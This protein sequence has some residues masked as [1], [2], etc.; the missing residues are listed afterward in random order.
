MI[1]KEALLVARTTMSHPMGHLQFHRERADLA[2]QGSDLELHVRAGFLAG[3]IHRQ[4]T[5]VIPLHQ[6]TQQGVTYASL[7]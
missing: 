6:K 4:L 2:F 3:G 7:G 1:D 5:G